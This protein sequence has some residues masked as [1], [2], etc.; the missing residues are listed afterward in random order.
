[1]TPAFS[2]K[3]GSRGKSQQRCRQGQIASADNQRQTV[4][5]LMRATK[6]CAT[7][8][9]AISVVEKRA[10]GK[11]CC[12]GNS[13]A[14]ALICTTSC[15]GKSGRTPTACLLDQT[16][17]TLGVIALAPLRD[18]L[19]WQRQARGDLAIVVARVR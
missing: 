11:S 5:P 6:P 3:A 4:L 17:R 14:R 13:Q 12:A 18:D 10:K 16:R 15:G 8:C 2:A 7:D 9:R 19:A 1:M